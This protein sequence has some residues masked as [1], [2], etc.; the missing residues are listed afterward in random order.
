MVPRGTDTDSRALCASLTT[1]MPPPGAI[2][3]GHGYA[4]RVKRML[5]VSIAVCAIT[6]TAG[7]SVSAAAS[8]PTLRAEPPKT[9]DPARLAE[10]P[11]Q[12]TDASG[13]GVAFQ[14]V[15]P[16]EP[17]Y[18]CDVDGACSVLEVYA[19]EECPGG[20]DV[21]AE[22]IDGSDVAD[23][24]EGSLDSLSAGESGFIPLGELTGAGT[25]ITVTDVVCG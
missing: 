5:A 14:W 21:R 16:D 12:Y 23:E 7:C 13:S 1:E 2:E 17:G 25:Y 11:A 3:W 4:G 19:Y 22:I 24:R 6:L 18:A 10:I 20:V 8:S 15:T 9:L